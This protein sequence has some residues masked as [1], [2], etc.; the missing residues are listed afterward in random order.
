MSQEDHTKSDYAPRYR[1][2][3]AWQISDDLA[4]DVYKLAKRLPKDEYSLKDQIVR[5]AIS[6]PANIAEGYGRGSNREFAQS[7]VAAHPSLYE[8]DYFLHFL[9]RIELVEPE[10]CAELAAECR[11]ASRLVYGLLRAASSDTRR[12]DTQRR[13]LREDYGFDFE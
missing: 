1:Q 3:K 7:L 9:N 10:R 11:Q 6:A 8:V 2:L 13:Y 4:V 12:K 5:A